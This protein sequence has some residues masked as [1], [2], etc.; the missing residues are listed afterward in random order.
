M[1]KS[2]ARITD[3]I[4]CPIPGHGNTAIAT[5]SPDVFFNGL[6]AARQGDT[7]T[8]GSALASGLSSTVFINGKN[9]AL[10]DTVGTHGDI[11]IGG[12]GSVIIG[13]IH[14]PASFVPPLSMNNPS[15][16]ISFHIST[17]ESYEGLG[18]VAHFEDGTSMSGVFDSNNVVRFSNASGDKCQTISLGA[19]TE[20]CAESVFDMYLETILK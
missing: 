5:G 2:A 11:V 17:T 20:V 1:V 6:A 15:S 16:W 18:C 14:V 8:C 10:V 12:S 19:K 9:A 7:C 4:S 3:P 13:D